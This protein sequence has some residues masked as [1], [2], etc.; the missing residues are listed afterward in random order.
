MIN[1]LMYFKNDDIFL[2]E[3]HVVPFYRNVIHFKR[4]VYD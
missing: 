1:M 3:T 2:I 4:H